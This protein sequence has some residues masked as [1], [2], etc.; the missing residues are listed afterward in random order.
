MCRT[1]A[2]GCR[3]APLAGIRVPVSR[4]EVQRHRPYFGGPAPRNLDRFVVENQGG[5]LIIRTGTIIQT[6]R[7]PVLTVQYPQGPSCI[8]AVAEA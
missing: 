4:V 8:S 6:P 5:N 2:A 7:A 3:G 1:S